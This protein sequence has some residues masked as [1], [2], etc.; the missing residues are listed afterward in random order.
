MPPFRQHPH[1]TSLREATFSRRAGRRTRVTVYPAPAPPGPAPARGRR[2]RSPGRWAPAPRASPCRAGS[3]RARCPALAP[4][5]VSCDGPSTST[6]SLASTQAKSTVKAPTGTCR[7]NLAPSCRSRRLRQRISSAT[8]CP[9]RR[10][11]ARSRR[12]SD[13]LGAMTLHPA[14]DEDWLVCKGRASSRRALLLPHGGRRWPCAAGSD[15]GASGRGPDRAALACTALIR[16]DCVGPPS[17]VGG[18]RRTRVVVGP[19]SETRAALAVRSFSRTAGEGGP[20]VRKGRMRAPQEEA[21]TVPPSPAPPSSD[22]TAS[23]HPGSSPG[24]ALLPSSREKEA[25]RRWTGCRMDWRSRRALLLPHRGRRWPFRQKGSDEGVSERGPIVPPS[26]APP[27]SDPTASGHLLPS[28]TGEGRA[29]SLDRL[30]DGLALS[31][32]APSPAPREKVALSSE[33]VG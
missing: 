9:R 18:G 11:R 4:A 12:C 23:G 15:E 13:V 8:V 24:Q 7:R 21:P 3:G 20:F 26:P 31:P 29:S 25:R 16:P 14:W 32:R 27:S 33:R 6:T 5:C 22:P 19:S 2:R 28:G 30:P 1:P 17:P 10:V